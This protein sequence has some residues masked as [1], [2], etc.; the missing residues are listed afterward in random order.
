MADGIFD[1]W[2]ASVQYRRRSTVQVAIVDVGNGIVSLGLGAIVSTGP[3]RH[4]SGD[5]NG[6]ILQSLQHVVEVGRSLWVGKVRWCKAF[7]SKAGSL[8]FDTGL[9][10]P[11]GRL[12]SC[13]TAPAMACR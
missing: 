8:L 2:D 12:L 11:S 1:H 13:A 4:T 10:Q 7:P 5:V 3:R 9:S 6:F